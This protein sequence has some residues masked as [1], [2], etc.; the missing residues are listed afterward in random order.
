MQGSDPHDPPSDARPWR[1]RPGWACFSSSQGRPRILR[2]PLSPL[3]SVTPSLPEVKANLTYFVFS[4]YFSIQAGVESVLR[5][6]CE[7]KWETELYLKVWFACVLGCARLLTYAWM[8]LYVAMCTC[9]SIC[10]WVCTRVLACVWV[11]TRVCMCGC[12]HVLPHTL[13][14]CTHIHCVHGCCVRMV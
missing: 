13:C 8:C 10:E 7:E 9:V 4:S 12:A 14:G 3:A 2:S 11:C 1:Q 6:I 5:E